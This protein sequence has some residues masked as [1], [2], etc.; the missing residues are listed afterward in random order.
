M[1][2]WLL[3]CNESHWRIRDFFTDGRTG[4]V[5][6]IRRHRDQIAAGDDVG[7]WLSGKQGGVVAIG[8]VTGEPCHGTATEADE[9]YW[10]GTHD[11]ATERW[12]VPVEFSRHF[13][14]APIRR[15]TLT[16][17]HRF[18]KSL[19]LR[20]PRGANPFP[21]AA[22][23]WAA[24]TDRVP[25]AGPHMIAA[26]VRGAAAVVAAGATAVREAFRSAVG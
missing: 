17:D 8:R 4:T 1:A 16:A 9:R 19:I 3:Q 7:V 10:T 14:D 15:D 18:A 11:H 12:L 26:T 6:T 22:D 13:L 2:H 23:E 24:I 20:V 25:P 5:W 21:V